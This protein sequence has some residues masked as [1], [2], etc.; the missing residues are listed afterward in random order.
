M[1]PIYNTRNN[2]N[3]IKFN[4]KKGIKLKI[5]ETF[6]RSNYPDKSSLFKNKLNRK[7]NSI[8]RSTNNLNYLKKY[9]QNKNLPVIKALQKSASSDNYD[10]STINKTSML[11]SQ[12]KDYFKNN[13]SKYYS[14][15]FNK[16]KYIK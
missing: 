16:T 14:Q 4:D 5:N 7:D 11:M 9:E 3:K 1:T 8:Y 10:K 15:Y 6:S 12:K 13:L 2:N